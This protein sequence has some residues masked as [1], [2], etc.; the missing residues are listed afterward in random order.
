MIR[1]T[2]FIHR[3]LNEK[4]RFV[5]VQKDLWLPIKPIQPEPSQAKLKKFCDGIK[6]E[7]NLG[8]GTLKFTTGWL[9][10]NGATI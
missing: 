8:F 10:E 3:T 1:T 2:V 4:M 5:E 6:K 9:I 7:E